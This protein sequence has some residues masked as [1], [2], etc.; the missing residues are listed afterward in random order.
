MNTFHATLDYSLSL[1]R[2]VA[3]LAAELTR[4]RPLLLLLGAGMSVDSGIPDYR[5]KAGF[6]TAGGPFGGIPDFMS[7]LSGRELEY[8]AVESWRIWREQLCI[9][10]AAEPH[11][12]Y[13]YLAAIAKKRGDACFTVTSNGDALTVRAGFSA[14]AVHMC[15]GNKFMLQCSRPCVRKTWTWKEATGTHPSDPAVEVPRCPICEAPARPNVYFFGDSE[16]SYVWEAQQASAERFSAWIK[17]H[18][19][20]MLML[21]IGCGIGAPGLRLRAEKYLHDFPGS[22]LIRINAHETEYPTPEAES[23]FQ[24]QSFAVTVS[25]AAEEQNAASQAGEPAAIPEDWRFCAIRAEAGPL[26]LSLLDGYGKEG[27]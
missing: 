18:G 8:R 3:F 20:R 16:E 25:D 23:F 15:H 11:A 9:F 2:T 27:Q 14:N 21:E 17:R 6:Y 19:E 4:P 12:G 24:K 1:S 5:G 7:L 26:F 10:T 22:R 13:A